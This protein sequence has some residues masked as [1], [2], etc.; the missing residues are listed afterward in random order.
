MPVALNHVRKYR[1]FVC[2]M[3]GRWYDFDCSWLCYA[4]YPLYTFR[5]PRY[6]TK[7]LHEAGATFCRIQYNLAKASVAQTSL[8]VKLFVHVV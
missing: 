3:V 4:L 5:T 7:K 6:I 2:L 8:S 1:R